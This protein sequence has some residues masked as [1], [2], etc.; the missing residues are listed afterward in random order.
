MLMS[1]SAMAHEFTPTYPKL[2]QSYV[3]GVLVATM[4][5]FNLR[6][7]V[8]YYETGVFDK[9]WKN[10]PFATDNKLVFIKHLERKK[11]DVYI[12]DKDKA[13]ALYIC[14]KSKLIVK[15]ASKTSVSTRICS[16]IK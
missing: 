12:R 1:G 5:L 8:T 15:G 16:K 4:T 6:K 13:R 7:D 10:V 11:I 14:S 9:D 3:E 2:R